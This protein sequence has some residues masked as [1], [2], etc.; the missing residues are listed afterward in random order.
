MQTSLLK[1]LL[2]GSLLVILLTSCS[3]TLFYKYS[4]NELV[5]ETLVH[6][7]VNRDNSLLFKTKIKLYNKYFSGL[8]LLKQ[9]DSSTSHLVFVTELGMKMFDY[10]IRNNQF[11][12]TYVFEPLNKPNILKILERDLKIILLQ[13]LLNKDVAIY[14][15][16]KVNSAIYKIVDRTQK[17]FYYVNLTTKAVDKTIIKGRLFCKEKVNYLYND[18]LS[19]TQIKLKHK[20]FIR[21]KIELNNIPK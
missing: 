2:L 9:T 18:S 15:K 21:L 5:T 20:G 7:I 16:D 12:L 19:A 3:P 11:K 10:E 6:P 17:H 1:N 14:K 8:I 4:K 13:N